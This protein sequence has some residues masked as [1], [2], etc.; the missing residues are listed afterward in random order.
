M[1]CGRA[2]VVYVGVDGSTGEGVGCPLGTL[3]F[4]RKPS[5]RGPV[6]I[7]TCSQKLLALPLAVKAAKVVAETE[8]D[9]TFIFVGDCQAMLLVADCQN[10]VLPAS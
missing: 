8:Y 7:V 4:H 10:D 2:P 9:G 5:R 3:G 1:F 6:F